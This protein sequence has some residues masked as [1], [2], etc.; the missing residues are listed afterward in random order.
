MIDTSQTVATRTGEPSADSPGFPLACAQESLWFLEQMAPGTPRY[1]MPEGW[2]FK[3]PLN[4]QALEKALEALIQRHEILRT[5]FPAQD[6]K[7]RQVA[8]EPGPF[9]LETID[10]TQSSAG[11]EEARRF[12]EAEARRPFDLQRGPLLRVQ[13]L[14]L[15]AADHFLFINMHH[16]ISDAWSFGIFMKEVAELYR[17]FGGGAP[18]SLRD[19]PVQYADFASWQRESLAGVAFEEQLK[20]WK[21]QLAGPIPALNLPFDHP[22]P[23]IPSQRGETLFFSFP[24]RLTE[25]LKALSRG[26]DATLF[27]TVLAGFATLLHRYTGL[28]DLVVGSPLSGRDRVETEQLI[29]FFINTHGLRVDLRGDPT[30]VELIGRVRELTLAAY[31]NQSVPFERV[32]QSLQPDRTPG[33]HALFQVVFGLQTAF[34][35][36]W[37]MPGLETTRVELETGTSKF[38]WTVLLTETRR[39]LGLRFEYNADLF[40]KGT[41]ARA[42]AHFQKVLEEVANSPFKRISE[43]SLLTR[44]ER[45]QVLT[46]WNRT[47]RVY[48]QDQC[49][50]QVFEA[51]VKE[52]PASV[53]LAA[54]GIEITYG[55]LNARANR[56]ARR[57]QQ[58]GVEPGTPIGLCMERSPE[59]IVA[60]LAI[61]K[62]GAAYVPLDRATPRERLAFLIRDSGVKLVITDPASGME[63]DLPPETSVLAAGDSH[64]SESPENPGVRPAPEGLAYI[65]YTSGSTGLPK[66]TAIPH[67]AVVRLVRNTNYI[68]IVPQDVFLLLAPISFD[69]STFEIWGALLNGSKL[70]IAPPEQPSLEQLGRI[71]ERER[72][73]IL[74]LTAGLFHQMVD[75]QLERL[76][77]LRHLLAG[78]DC[79]SVSHVRKARAT[80]KD[81][82]LINGYGPTEN[83]TFS[84]CYRVP[85]G[86]SG[87]FSV[88]IGRPISNTRAYVLDAKLEPMPIGI[89]GELYLGGD[90][91]ALG[92]VKR[93][94]L[95]AE[96]FVVSPFHEFHRERLYRTGDLVRWLADGNLEFLGRMDNQVKIRGFRVEPG[97]VEAALRQ[98]PGVREAAVAPYHP[99][100]GIKVLVAYVVPADG[101]SVTTAGLRKFLE[102]ALPSY[103]VP[104]HFVQLDQLPLT[105][106]G[107]LDRRALP[108]P[109][110][111]KDLRSR[112][113]VAPRN[114][115]EERLAGIWSELL[116][117][118]EIGIHDNFFHL[119]GHSLLATQLVSRIARVFQAEVPVRTL[120]EKPT[121]AELAE[122]VGR[123]QRERPA[124]SGPIPRRSGRTAAEELLAR[125]DQLSEKELEEIL[126][127]PGFKHPIS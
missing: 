94:D 12:L 113:R 14:R 55:E 92:Y 85:E 114:P 98:C 4:P 47:D 45:Q 43:I 79:L 93:D 31:A 127:D 56:L 77:P 24:K 46:D 37:P 41:I 23:A 7:P 90:G 13:L 59:L 33:Q 18:A 32:V 29:G 74:W 118:R 80:L 100:G 83:T 70:L 49:I 110:Q 66:G 38:D 125:L 57:L 34:T 102:A 82:E 112:V 5:V 69:A 52:A 22:R 103:L 8:L 126:H 30:F 95:T 61:L 40:D 2:H 108:P 20:Y 89:P 25:S 51:R 53:A 17:G 123:I 115:A 73:T 54:R 119:G 39:D 1:N 16:M 50:H 111:E 97:E 99:D 65:I 101:S 15:G 26:E 104:T 121:I 48:E 64:E 63:T 60:M 58:R 21:T 122:A 106:N 42:A 88:P 75:N 116:G 6:G 67:R 10:L 91:L 78:G 84:C 107:K 105:P 68:E 11:E 3:G 72:I 86:W 27:M 19:L 117:V 28:E 87:D 81:C 9:S 124:G 76:K 36:D 62:A 35:E 71:I 109:D 96:K 120:F 44:A